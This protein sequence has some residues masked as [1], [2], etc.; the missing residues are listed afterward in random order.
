MK[1]ASPLDLLLQ[2]RRLFVRGFETTVRIGIHDFEKS[3]AQRMLF[4]VD[5]YVPLSVSTPRHD[6][7]DEVIDY[8]FI[9]RRI[10]ER[11]MQGHIHLQETLCDDLLAVMLA[12][13]GVRAARVQ[14]AKTDV[15]DDCDAVGCKRFAIKEPK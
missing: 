14:T 2:C 8:D 3:E 7:I 11:V 15:Y 6:R 4:D 9:R 13:P 1:D 5:L 10:V 12:H